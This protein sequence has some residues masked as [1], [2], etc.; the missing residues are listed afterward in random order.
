MDAV[1][2]ERLFAFLA[3]REGKADKTIKYYMQRLRRM[4]REGFRFD[5]FAKG[6]REAQDEGDR[7]LVQLRRANKT[8]DALRNVQKCLLALV[9]FHG[10]KNVGWRLQ[11]ERRRDPQI[12]SL[13]ELT[14]LLRLPFNRTALRR[15][16][17]AANMAHLALG[18]RAGELVRLEESHI[19]AANHRVFIAHPEKGAAPRWIPVHPVFFSAS[20]AFMSWVKHRP[21]APSRT[22]AVWTTKD[23]RGKVR[24]LDQHGLALVISRAGRKVGVKANCQRGRSTSLSADIVQGR[25]LAFVKHKAGHSGYNTLAHY[26]AYVELGMAKHLAKPGW[27]AYIPQ[28]GSSP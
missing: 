7:F 11:R 5:E 10:Y 20:R 28:E 13:T 23:R 6:D 2:H 1:L 9:R 22:H 14:A 16:E 26:V 25:D 4:E 27:F 15:L 18:W 21:R 19:D 8:P 24:V 17:R 12:Y 3:G